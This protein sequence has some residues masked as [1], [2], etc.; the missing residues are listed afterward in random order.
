MHADQATLAD[1]PPTTRSRITNGSRLLVGVDGRS[2]HARRYRDLIANISRDISG[3][4]ALL[5]TAERGL[6][7]QAATVFLRAEQ[8]QAAIVRGEPVDDDQ[9]IRLSG[10]VRRLLKAIP[11]R[12]RA[13]EPSD[14]FAELAALAEDAAEPGDEQ[15]LGDARG[16]VDASFEPPATLLSRRR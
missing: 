12:E 11:T 14:Y 4:G 1:R 9:L 6:I 3:A 10:E 13:A 5:S 7:K 2:A 8:L 15:P 16:S